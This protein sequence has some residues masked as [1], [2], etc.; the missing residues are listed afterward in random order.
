MSS[1][2]LSPQNLKSADELEAED[3]DAQSAKLQEL[4]R[5]GTSKDLEEA[6][7]LMKFLS[8]ANPEAKPDYRSQALHE[9]EK[10]ESKIVLLNE[11]LDNIDT[12]RGERP[13][14]GDVYE[15]RRVSP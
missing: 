7:K 13:T 5:R 1:D 2:A 3:R 8:G 4:I 14:A 12:S 11:M 15:V 9:V 6:Q 10:I